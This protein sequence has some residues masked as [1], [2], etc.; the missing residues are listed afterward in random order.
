[1]LPMAGLTDQVAVVPEGKFTTEK[2]CVPD[3]A[4]VTVTGLTLV[5]AGLRTLEAIRLTLPLEDFVVSATLVAVILTYCA[6]GML[7]GA[8]Y[9]PFTTAPTFGFSVQVT[10]VFEVPVTVAA[11]S[12][13]CPA[14]RVKFLGFRA[15]LTVGYEVDGL[16]AGPS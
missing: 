11:S 7:V 3:G 9:R 4:T 8:T 10:A 1:M 6:E 15:T 5:A 2:V 14:E 13:D 12:L 16:T